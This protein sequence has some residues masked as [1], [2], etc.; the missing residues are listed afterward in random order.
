MV[1]H[2]SGGLSDVVTGNQ[3]L[4]SATS[5]GSFLFSPQASKFIRDNVQIGAQFGLGVE[6]GDGQSQVSVGVVPFYRM[7]VR[8]V[9]KWTPYIETGM[10]PFYVFNDPFEFY[11][12]VGH[13]FYGMDYFIMERVAV[14][15]RAGGTFTYLSNNSFTVGF[16]IRFGIQLLLGE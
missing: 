6:F 10:G 14:G 9:K 5:K 8:G 3:L 16:P 15:A 4:F 2:I 12:G 13:F 11:G 1:G 7:N